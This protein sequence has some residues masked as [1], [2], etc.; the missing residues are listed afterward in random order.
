MSRE[1]GGSKIVIELAEEMEHLGW[2]CDLISP[3]D[4][5]SAQA[6][7]LHEKYPAYLR[8]YLHEHASQ[9]DVVDYNHSHLPYPRSEFPHQTLFVTRSVLLSHHFDKIELPKEKGLKSSIRSLLLA[10]DGEARHKRWL[11]RAYLTL[12]EADLINVP[13]YDDKAELVKSGVAEDKIVVIPYGISRSSRMLFDAVSSRTP[14]E[15]RVAFVGTFDNRKGATDFPEIVE[16]V[17]AAVPGVVFR[18]LG[19]YKDEAKVLTSFPK[20]L[21][22]SIEVIPHYPAETLPELL[23]LCSVGVFPSYIEGFGLGVL[24]MLAASIPVVAY[25][26]PGPPMMLTSEYLVPRGD[27]GALSE[28]VIRLLK[29]KERLAEARLWARRQSQQFCWKAIARQTGDVYKAQWERKQV[30]AVTV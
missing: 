14:V 30:Q 19:T 5:V 22:R 7:E 27:A 26:S 8:E 28:K 25:N 29:D 3:S 24:E 21:R 20:K 9:Y 1:L 17:R 6:R 2:R 12:N 10:R 13:N 11:R 23:S 16:R 4:I 18:L 15:P